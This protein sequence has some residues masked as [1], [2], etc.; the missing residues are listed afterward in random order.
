MLVVFK[1][2]RLDIGKPVQKGHADRSQGLAPDSGLLAG[3]VRRVGLREH[4]V[5]HTENTV[6]E[7]LVGATH[8]RLVLPEGHAFLLLVRTVSSQGWTASSASSRYRAALTS[9]RWVNAC[10]KFP[11]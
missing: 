1:M 11:R 5:D 6:A 10:G 3:E 9:P 4:L 7:P 2:D 8:N